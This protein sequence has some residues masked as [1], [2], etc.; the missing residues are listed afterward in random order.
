[1]L[2]SLCSK[3]ATSFFSRKPSCEVFGHLPARAREFLRLPYCFSHH[4]PQERT[5]SLPTSR[6]YQHRDAPPANDRKFQNLE[7]VLTGMDFEHIFCRRVFYPYSRYEITPYW[8]NT[9]LT[10]NAECCSKAQMSLAFIC[11]TLHNV[12]PQAIATVRETA[13]SILRS[14]MYDIVSFSRTHKLIVLRKPHCG[15]RCS[16]KKDKVTRERN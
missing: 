3:Y 10:T 8:K 5:V 12:R 13:S 4:G 1:M 7:H 11:T 15:S 16:R 9:R 14:T 2:S 6:L